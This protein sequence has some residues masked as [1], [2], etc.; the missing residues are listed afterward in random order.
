MGITQAAAIM[1]TA[2]TVVSNFDHIGVLPGQTILIHGGTGGIGSFAIPYAKHLGL[3]VITTVGS[4]SKAAHAHTMGADVAIDYHEDWAA[5]VAAA[6]SGAGVDAILDIMGAKYLEANINSL[7]RN[8]RMVVIGLQGGTKGTLDLNRLLTKAA[9]ITATS[10]R[11][12]P[13]AEKAEI[14][15]QVAQRVWPLF[16]TRKISLPPITTFPLA[17]A[18]AAHQLLESGDLVGKIVLTLS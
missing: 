6:T 15:H 1:E 12:R 9:T 17:Q 8:G 5:E 13:S 7:A 11:F 3:R 18:S 2:A 16:E 14:V 4:Q 10:L